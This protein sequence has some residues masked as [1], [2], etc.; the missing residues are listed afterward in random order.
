MTDLETPSRNTPPASFS[1]R[2]PTDFKIFIGVNGIR[3][4]WRLLAGLAI[5]FT[6]FSGFSSVAFYVPWLRSLI[7]TL[8]PQGILSGETAI[9]VL[10]LISAGLMSAI[11]GR[12]LR[13]YGMG[14]EG[15]FGRNFWI[16]AVAGFASISV[17]L[18]ALRIAGGYHSSGLALHGGPI[19]RFGALWLIAFLAV[20]FLE[21]NG[22]RGYVV[23]TLTTGIGF[24]PA[25]IL[26]S[27]VFG[28]THLGNTGES[29]VGA[30]AVACMGFF[31][32]ILLRKTGNLWAPMGFHMAWDWGE[33][34]FYGVPDSGLPASGHLYSAAFAGPVWLT[35]GSVGPEASFFCLILIAILCVA[36]S[37]VPGAKY[38]NPEAIPDP[39]RRLKPAASL[40]SP[41]VN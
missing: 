19:W 9:F 12:H 15:A 29:L 41:S 20:A 31:F 32:C 34:F 10:Y 35:G 25:A 40:F 17:L 27:I 1:S 13:D 18:F 16:C 22:F 2:P 11:E 4:G 3:A 24:W 23:F 6:L 36:A 37:F 14:I 28:A 33:T 26:L 39:R 21:E 30:L 5:F 7:G 8:T 38:P